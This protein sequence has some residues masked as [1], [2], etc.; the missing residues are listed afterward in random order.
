MWHGIQNEKLIG[1]KIGI[2]EVQNIVDKM[3][4]ERESQPW[5]LD[6]NL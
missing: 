4:A 3:V 2:S 1:E 5:I 6:Y